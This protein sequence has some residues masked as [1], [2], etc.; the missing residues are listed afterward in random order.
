MDLDG[1]R[2]TRPGKVRLKD[3]PTRLLEAPDKK[4]L[5]E[6]VEKD[7]ERIIELQ[8]LLY[9]QRAHA[10]LLIF[11]AMDA[12]GKDSCIGH[13]LG[14]V[15][16]QGCRVWGFKAP[17]AEEL[18]HD[19]LWRHAQAIPARGL[20]GVHSRSHYEEVLAV[21]VHPEYLLAQRIPNVS[22]VVQADADFWGRRYASIQGFEEH[23]AEQGVVIMKFFL[24]MS[25]A[26]QKERLLER[27][28]DPEKNWKFNIGDLNERARW[29]EYHT[30]YEAAIGATAA[31]HAPWHI[32]PADE[33][34]E[35]RA[36]VAALVRERLEAMDLR[37]PVL[38]DKAKAELVLAREQLSTKEE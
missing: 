27:V 1:F 25:K 2:I 37:H 18:S 35:T 30:A 14:G 17:N 3:Y 31:E 12:A 7:R 22:S 10:A 20:I 6:S 19:F 24:H 26:A 38:S 15:N 28:D 32:V 21:K 4:K 34:W 5:K 23:L 33:Q 13:V 11:Q 16:P 36:I 8:E 9:A 29:N